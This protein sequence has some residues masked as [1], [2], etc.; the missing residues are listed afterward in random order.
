MKTENK[1]NRQR[2]N[3]ELCKWFK[4]AYTDY[5]KDNKGYKNILDYLSGEYD[6]DRDF[7]AKIARKSGLHVIKRAGIYFIKA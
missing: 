6:F 2:V 1:S 3:E 7:W 5:T 4:V